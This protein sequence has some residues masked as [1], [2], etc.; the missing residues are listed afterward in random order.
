MCFLVLPHSTE[1]HDLW[2]PKDSSEKI[3]LQRLDSSSLSPAV[4]V[5]ISP[6]SQGASFWVPWGFACLLRV[7]ETANIGIELVVLLLTQDS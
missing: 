5:W 3:T 1:L 6:V 7:D 2:Q 4:E